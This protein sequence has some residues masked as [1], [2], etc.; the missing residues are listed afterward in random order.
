MEWE[1]IAIGA[2]FV[3]GMFIGKYI[4]R[5]EYHDQLI[6]EQQQKQQMEMWAQFMKG[7]KQ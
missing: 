3:L 7:G 1:I 2:S 6:R 4:G 5:Q